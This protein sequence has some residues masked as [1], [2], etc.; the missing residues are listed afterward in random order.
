MCALGLGTA[1]AATPAVA[2]DIELSG[3]PPQA[4]TG[5]AWDDGNEEVLVTDETGT[6]TVVDPAVGDGRAFTFT[7]QPDSVQALGMFKDWLYIGDVGDEDANRDFVTVFRVDGSTNHRAWDFSYPEGAQDAKAMAISG[8]GRIY[9][10]TSGD[11]PG[12]YR[13]GLEP[14]ATNV[15]ALKRAADAPKGVTD[16]VFLDDGSTLM[17]RTEDGVDLVDA[18][19]WEVQAA[20]TY[21]DGPE[22]ES[23]TLFTQDRMLVGGGTLLRDEPLPDGMTTVTPVPPAEPT[24]TAS[25]SVAE[26]PEETATVSPSDAPAESQTSEVSRSGTLFALGGAAVVALLAGVFVFLVRD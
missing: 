19:T 10:V 16:A 11:D 15:N 13:A 22:G 26:T 20:T 2:D 8:K 4:I 17:L 12:I 14:S 25:A 5:I 6:I 21:V 9:I 3:E 23:I 1:V 7:G 24:P 18:Y